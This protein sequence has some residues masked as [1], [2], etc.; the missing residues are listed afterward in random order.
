MELSECAP[1][2]FA[3]SF[4]Q[5]EMQSAKIRNMPGNQMSKNE[6]RNSQKKYVTK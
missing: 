1:D 4:F 5:R 2:Q 6:M 3:E